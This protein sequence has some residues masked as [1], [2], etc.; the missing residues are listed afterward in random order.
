MNETKLKKL[1]SNNYCNFN[2]IKKLFPS[3][4]NSNNNNNNN[5]MNLKMDDVGKYNVHYQKLLV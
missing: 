5:L 3:I 2:V 4:S 1:Y